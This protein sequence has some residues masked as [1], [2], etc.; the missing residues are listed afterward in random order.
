MVES[1]S[2]LKHPERP[3]KLLAVLAACLP[4]VTGCISSVVPSLRQPDRLY[5]ID[6]EVGR[7]RAA[8]DSQDLWDSYARAPSKSSRNAYI[9]ARMYAI[10]ILYT[11]YESQ[12][13]H[14]NQEVNFLATATT[15]GLN[16]VGALTTVAS[17]TRLLSGIAGG[18][19]GMDNAYNDKVLLS[20]AVQNVQTQMR[21]NRAEQAALIFANLKCPLPNYPMGMALSDVEAYYRAGTFT[22]GLIKL[23]ETVNKAE[24]EAKAK[25]DVQTPASPPE[26]TAKLMG[27]ADVKS[28][29]TARN[30]PKCP[31]MAG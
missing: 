27:E 14:E 20:K 16:T 21:A 26:A 13:T 9:T 10:D 1:E 23:S 2:K 6:E 31:S 11:K 30:T 29:Q 7:V 25:K 18:I 24:A 28:A 3:L 17:T 12:L 19:T 8:L 15:L 4:A 5:S 22:A